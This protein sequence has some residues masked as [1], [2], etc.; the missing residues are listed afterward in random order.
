MALSKIKSSFFCSFMLEEEEEKVAERSRRVL[1][2]GGVSK[3]DD[4]HFNPQFK[5]FQKHK[6]NL[7]LF[8]MTLFF[9]L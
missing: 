7:N 4:I 3:E 2:V 8:S 9:L 6:E 1:S 5:F